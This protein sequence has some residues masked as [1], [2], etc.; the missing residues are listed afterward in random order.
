MFNLL[1]AHLLNRT[2][3]HPDCTGN[4]CVSDCSTQRF[5]DQLEEPLM[6]WEIEAEERLTQRRMQLLQGDIPA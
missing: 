4:G 6:P 2:E 3:H 5:L 1:Y